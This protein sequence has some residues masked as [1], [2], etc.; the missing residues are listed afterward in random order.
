MNKNASAVPQEKDEVIYAHLHA[1]ICDSKLLP[2]TR[3]PEDTLSVSFGVSRTVVRKV[4]QRLACE[5]LV[6]M[7]PN[8]GAQVAE[9]SVNEARDIFAT[10]RILECGAL[11]EMQ[12]PIPAAKLESLRALVEAEDAAQMSGNRVDAIRLS[13]EFHIELAALT[14][15]LVLTEMVAKLVARS[16]LIIATYGSP[17][18]VVCRH[19]EHEQIIDLLARSDAAGAAAWMQE[20]LLTIERGLRWEHPASD[21]QEVLRGVMANARGGKA[22]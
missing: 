3:L 13:G 4:L 8:R 18:A 15:N 12:N 22:D 21:L 7:R 17:I 1:A 10:R 20:H 11:A 16:S 9:P 5:G 19:S 2:G 6:A 14:G